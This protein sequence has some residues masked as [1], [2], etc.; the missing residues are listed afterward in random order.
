MWRVIDRVDVDVRAASHQARLEGSASK[1]GLEHARVPH[2]S[3]RRTG[4]GY[5][6][7]AL[8]AGMRERWPQSAVR[9]YTD[10]RSMTHEVT[11]DFPDSEFLAIWIM[12]PPDTLHA[13]TFDVGKLGEFIEWWVQ[14]APGFDP[15]VRIYNPQ[16]RPDPCP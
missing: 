14:R 7:P 2:R 12:S 11:V 9:E 6:P 8:V 4:L 10:G 16:I 3:R 15:D 5:R 13:E 1:L